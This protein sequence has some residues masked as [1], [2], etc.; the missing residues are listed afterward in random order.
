ME[1]AAGRRALLGS[2]DPGSLEGI[3][4]LEADLGRSLDIV[5]FFQGWGVEDN[6]FDADRA[7]AIVARGAEPMVTWEPWDYRRGT[8][9]PEY[10]LRRIVAGD[11]DDY[12]RQWGRD[13]RDFGHE[14]LL[15]FAHEMNHDAY[16]WGVG[17]Q[18]NT[19][20]DYVRAWR[21]VVRLVRAEGAT[22]VRFVWCPVAP[23]PG[24]PGLRGCFPGDRFVDVVGMDGYNAGTAADWGGWLSFTEIFGPLYRRVRR[25]SD[26]PVMVC[27]TGCAEE[28]GNKARWITRAFQRELPQRF[29]AVTAVVWFNERREA[30]W[31]LDSSPATLEAARVAF[32]TSGFTR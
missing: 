6:R 15:R 14:V 1:L 13:L 9:Q 26:R 22:N 17:V 20:R 2:W 12:I 29:P 19:G 10:R 27:E 21:R 31:R 5:H 25:L 30:D 23:Y 32:R 3:A 24:S 28:G 16:P 8:D 11:H 4:A 18:G 7:A